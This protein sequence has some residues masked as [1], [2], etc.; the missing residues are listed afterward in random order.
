VDQIVAEIENKMAEEERL[1]EKRRKAAIVGTAKF[2]TQV[3]DPF[4][5][6]GLTPREDRVWTRGKQLTLKQ[7]EL[8]RRQGVDPDNLS[9]AEGQQIINHLFHRWENKL[10]TLK[11]CQLLKRYG[12]DARNMGMAEASARIDSIASRGWRM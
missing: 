2:K 1:K 7:Q 11:Q 9:Y 12:V 3:V 10:A 6:L 8:L 5:A 4:T